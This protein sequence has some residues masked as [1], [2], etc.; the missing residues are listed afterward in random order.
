MNVMG[1]VFGGRSQLLVINCQFHRD[2]VFGDR[3][4]LLVINCQFLEFTLSFIY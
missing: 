1:T 2:L 4:Q 3:S